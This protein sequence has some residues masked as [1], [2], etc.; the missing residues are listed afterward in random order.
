MIEEAISKSEYCAHLRQNEDNFQER[1]ENLN[2]LIAK[3]HLWQSLHPS[4]DFCDFFQEIALAQSHDLQNK[5]GDQA[6]QLMT[7]HHSKGLEF[8][9]VFVVGLEEQLFPHV[10]SKIETP[11]VEEERRLLYV[12]MTRAMEKL[13]LSYTKRRFMWGT[14][15]QMNP[16]RFLFEIPDLTD[17]LEHDSDQPIFL[18]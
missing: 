4:D 10:Y 7:V 17:T 5:H 2:E 12:A 1:E 14:W 16:S 6:V 18:Y 11:D 9:V 8:P 15:R 3:A 13:T